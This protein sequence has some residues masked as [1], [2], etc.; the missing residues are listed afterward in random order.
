MSEAIPAADLASPGSACRPDAVR[1]AIT[2]SPR[3]SALVAAPIGD[4]LRRACMAH[5]GDR[6]AGAASPILAG[7]DADGR[8]LQ[9][10]RHA[11]YLAVDEDQDGL[12]DHLIVWAP[13]GLGP[14][15]IAAL[16]RLDVL[17]G[18]SHLTGVR[19]CRLSLEA[20]GAITHVAPSLTGPGQTWRSLTPF[21][22]P[23]HSKRRLS[24]KEH[25]RIQVAE[26]LAH[27]SQPAPQ[28]VD[29]LP[30]DWRAYRRHRIGIGPEDGRRATGLKLVF[31][32][33]VTGPLALGRLSHYGLGLFLPARR[34]PMPRVPQ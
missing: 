14:Q 26:E 22:P 34:P 2:G 29:L 30:G 16:V 27:R 15:E 21:I 13:D 31:K 20:V 8:P 23:R 28:I 7:K 32:V 3:A 18:H 25:V 11:H 1:W 33:P 9:N 6:F 17:A 24:W 4:L 5:F 12:L 10:H 19:Q